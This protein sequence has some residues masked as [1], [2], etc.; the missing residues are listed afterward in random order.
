[1]RLLYTVGHFESKIHAKKK[2][3][4]FKIISVMALVFHICTTLVKNLLLLCIFNFQNDSLCVCY[5]L[6]QPPTRIFASISSH[7][8][9]SY[10]EILYFFGG[11]MSSAAAVYIHRMAIALA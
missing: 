10:F 1:M 4:N 3:E 11:L 2:W 7:E 5:N 8:K 6:L 9:N